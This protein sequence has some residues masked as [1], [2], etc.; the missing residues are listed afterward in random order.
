[1]DYPSHKN[2]L[3]DRPQSAHY[4]NVCLR[5]LDEKTADGSIACVRIGRA[6]R[7]RVS[8]L[9]AFVSANETTV[10]AKRRAATRGKKS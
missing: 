3:L 5:T 9:D 6:V 2:R 8:A 4:L 10:P 1:M 7:F